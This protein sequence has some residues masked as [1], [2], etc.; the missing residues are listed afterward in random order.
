MNKAI[1]SVPFSICQCLFAGSTSVSV[2]ENMEHRVSF[3]KIVQIL[4]FTLRV[5]CS[6]TVISKLRTI[7]LLIV[8]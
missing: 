4:F 1:E 2:E 6:T 7:E 8:T 3:F 5:Y